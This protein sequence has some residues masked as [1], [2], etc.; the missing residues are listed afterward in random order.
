MPH[1][2]SELARPGSA[3]RAERLTTRTGA[4]RSTTDQLRQK[5]ARRYPPDRKTK[6]GWG[7]H[8][9]QGRASRR[10]HLFTDEPSV[11]PQ[12]LHLSKNTYLLTTQAFGR[13]SVDRF[14]RRTRVSR[15]TV[16]N[17]QIG[18][19]L[20]IGF[21][22]WRQPTRPAQSWRRTHS[23][24]ARC[25]SDT[26]TAFTQAV[27]QSPSPAPPVTFVERGH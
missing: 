20:P 6:L 22:G 17:P 25:Q 9:K 15:P 18:F 8:P 4:A 27:L 24:S 3:G 11:E 16:S 21:A 23:S 1:Q 2:P 7:I 14:S 12:D 26:S 13:A 10:S 19:V 5:G